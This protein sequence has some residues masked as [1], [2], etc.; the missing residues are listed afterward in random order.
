MSSPVLI[1]YVVRN[2]VTGEM[3]AYDGELCEYSRTVKTPRV[4]LTYGEALHDVADLGAEMRSMRRGAEDHP[5][6][7]ES[8]RDAWRA[9]A[10]AWADFL[11]AAEIQP[12]RVG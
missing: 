8:L 2:T 6:C 7:D 9:A 12:L 3:L 11:T 1:G 4:H 10:A 5:S